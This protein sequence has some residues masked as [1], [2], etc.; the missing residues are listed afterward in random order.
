MV[1][2]DS[3]ASNGSPYVVII[4]ADDSDTDTTDTESTAFVWTVDKLPVPIVLTPLSDQNNFEGD[5]VSLQVNATGG[6]GT[7]VFSAT[8]LPTGLS[9]DPA[10]G[11]ISGT[12]ATGAEA[13]S[14]YAVQV[15]VDDSDGDPTDIVNT[16]FTWTVDTIPASVTDVWLEAECGN[17]GANW[18]ELSDPSASNGLYL[19][20][21][22]SN[23]NGS[24]SSNSAN[25][26]NFS[27][28]VSEAGQY[29]IFGRTLAPNT[30]DDSYWVRVN[31]GSWVKWN[32]I[33]PSSSFA[34]S[35]VHD[36]QNNNTPVTFGLVAGVNTLDIAGR[37][38]GTVIDKLFITLNGSTPIGAGGGAANCPGGI[39]IS[40]APISDQISEEGDTIQFSVDAS[41]GDGNLTYVAMGLPPGLSIDPT[42]GEISGIV[43]ETATVG[44]PYSVTITVDDA[45]LIQTD[46]KS[47][48]F[49]WFVI[50]PG[51]EP[52]EI[53]LEA[54]CATV[55]A[56]WTQVS[57]IAAS[58]GNY[59][60]APNQN[61][62]GSPSNSNAERVI[63]NVN[64]SIAGQ[65][66][67]FGRVIAPNTN[68]D[69]FWVRAN[70]GDWVRW[71]NI[72]PSTSFVWDQV[73]DDR[74]GITP[75]L[76]DLQSGNNTI[77]FAGRESGAILDKIYL[78]LDGDTPTGL[79]VAADNCASQLHAPA[80]QTSLLDNSNDP[81]DSNTEQSTD[82]SFEYQIEAYPNPLP[83][84]QGL[85][86]LEF[87]R[88]V[89]EAV[90]YML[91]DMHGRRIQHASLDFQS[92]RYAKIQ[93]DPLPEGLYMLVLEGE[94]F[95]RMIRLKVISD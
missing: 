18:T 74:G 11:L 34:W 72:E 7:L 49:L 26:I 45:D 57:D 13:N 50:S 33:Q 70:D 61:Y 28:E 19:E 39:P 65:Y 6:D 84:E 24:P 27:F 75:V 64:I 8:G 66:K 63:F 12:I 68:D 48:S 22:G 91:T 67:V 88:Q 71:N 17:V 23:F 9:I 76:F 10:S 85:L 56:S 42:T 81:S 80:N 59:L 79:G 89:K 30:N 36:N 95:V 73:H 1:V 46:E 40:L 52:S 38:N 44:S 69:S 78:T 82:I 29:K 58:N 54:E 53:W 92:G 77:E 47:I 43:D 55:G 62:H 14:P 93:I 83:T 90:K 41:G 37:E 3:T 5:P 87:D 4:T 60:L 16:S 25:R 86:T 94:S 21:P 2:I 35:Q 15:E 51:T 32:E 20:S 31:G